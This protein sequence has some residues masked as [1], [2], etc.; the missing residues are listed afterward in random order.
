M[1]DIICLAP[2]AC[3]DVFQRR[4]AI[5]NEPLSNVLRLFRS[6]TNI[7]GKL[8]DRSRNEGDYDEQETIISEMQYLVEEH[9]KSS[10]LFCTFTVNNAAIRVN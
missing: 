4:S 6:I 3:S 7:I 9:L 1:Y 8:W 10:E 5:I 2:I